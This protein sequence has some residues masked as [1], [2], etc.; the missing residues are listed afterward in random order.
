MSHREQMWAPWLGF[1][2]RRWAFNALWAQVPSSPSA[3]EGACLA[4]A[5]PGRG[6]RAE[7]GGG[8][9]VRAPGSAGTGSRWPEDGPRWPGLTTWGLLLPRVP[10]PRARQGPCGPLVCLWPLAA[11]PPAG[12]WR[13]SAPV[14]DVGRPG[15]WCRSCSCGGKVRGSPCTHAVWVDD[16]IEPCL[17]IFPSRPAARPLCPIWLFRTSGL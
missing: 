15:S 12:P 3:L 16:F 5:W 1:C 14:P 4:L 9:R 8:V 6:Q 2:P 13:S 11:D 17:I 10:R 7:G